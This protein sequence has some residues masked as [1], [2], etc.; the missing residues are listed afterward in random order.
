MGFCV[1]SI[2]G[3]QFRQWANRNL[4]EY[5]RKGLVID[6]GRLKK[7]DGCPDYF[8]ELLDRIRDI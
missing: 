2:L 5:L 3:V 7:T 8:D 1:R 4:T 6:Y